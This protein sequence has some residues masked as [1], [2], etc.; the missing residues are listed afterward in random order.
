MIRGWEWLL[1]SSW[2]EGHLESGANWQPRLVQIR[3]VVD[4]SLFLL[5]NPAMNGVNLAVDG[6]WLLL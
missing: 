3:D 2:L 4:A 5:E 6:G 1:T